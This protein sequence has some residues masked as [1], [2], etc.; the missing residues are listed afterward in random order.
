MSS[1]AKRKCCCKTKDGRKCGRAFYP[2]TANQKYCWQHGA[3]RGYNC[4]VPQPK[5]PRSPTRKR[6]V[7]FASNPVTEIKEISG[8]KGSHAE[9][10]RKAYAAIKSPS[11]RQYNCIEYI[12]SRLN[13]WD[14][15]DLRE[16]RSSL[17]A[18]ELRAVQACLKAMKRRK[19][20]KAEADLIVAMADEKYQ[21]M[22]AYRRSRY[23]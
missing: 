5:C 13:V 15:D 8:K 18:R 7:R 23:T 10:K 3:N 19:L 16:K 20:T 11:E 1:P 14:E 21:A 9:M 22:E 17:S 4:N 2:K 6:G 12:L